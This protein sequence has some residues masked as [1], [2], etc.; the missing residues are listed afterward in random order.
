M[1]VFDTLLEVQGHDTAADQLHHRRS[2]LPEQ[3]ELEANAR[4][5]AVVAAELAQAQARRDDV[6]GRQAALEESITVADRRI[7]EI[8]GR[9]YSGQVTAT[10][11]ILAMTAEIESLKARRSSLE[12]DVL[13][14]M[15]E[16]E[17]L[18]ADVARL[19]DRLV[20]LEDDA[21][22]LRA[23]IATAEGEIDAEAEVVARA[24]ASGASLVPADLL[25]TY[26]RLRAT[27]GGVGAARLIGSSCSGCHLLLPAQEVARIKRE[28][29]DALVQ[30]DQCG[31]ILVR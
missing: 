16:D 7:T 14:T 13:A 20:A 12:D 28:A 8:D 6:L 1:S 10:R 22:R 21:A 11:D 15:E 30:C 27:L 9:L 5:A 25:A 23:A 29:L 24:R 31:R 17:P 18:S 3:A 4:Q 26:E 19:Q 2:H